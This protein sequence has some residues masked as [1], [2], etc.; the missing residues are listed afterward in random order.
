MS[1][2]KWE[3]RQAPLREPFGAE[4]SAYDTKPRL[5][6]PR[7]AIVEN[8][9]LRPSSSGQGPL[10]AYMDLRGS[11]YSGQDFSNSGI[12]LSL[13]IPVDPRELPLLSGFMGRSIQVQRL[14]PHEVKDLEDLRSKYQQLWETYQ[15]LVESLRELLP[16]TP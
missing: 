2:A 11:D 5:G 3:R 13:R 8:L 9:E 7:E 4:L 1:I 14:E 15:F 10:V 6:P 16:Q 12:V